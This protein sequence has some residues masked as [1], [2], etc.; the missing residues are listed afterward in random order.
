[1]RGEGYVPLH[2]QEEVNYILSPHR[3]PPHALLNCHPKANS[4]ETS[5]ESTL[6]VCN[7]TK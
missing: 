1:M 6:A 7:K 5:P 3:T 2:I 4:L